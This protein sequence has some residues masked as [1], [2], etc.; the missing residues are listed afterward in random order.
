[1]KKEIDQLQQLDEESIAAR[2]ALEATQDKQA[3]LQKCLSDTRLSKSQV[4][5]KQFHHS[6]FR[7]HVSKAAKER[8]CMCFTQI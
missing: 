6:Q 1:M 7:A 3:L 5:P 2:K 8:R 4:G